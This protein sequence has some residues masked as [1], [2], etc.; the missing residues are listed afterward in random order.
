MCGFAPNVVL[1]VVPHNCKWLTYATVLFCV[2]CLP[3]LMVVKQ[4]VL[5]IIYQLRAVTLDLLHKMASG[6]LQTLDEVQLIAELRQALSSVDYDTFSE[7]LDSET[8]FQ[9]CPD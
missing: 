1:C 6:I 3:F 5:V 9:G 4:L 7:G 2:A 8:R